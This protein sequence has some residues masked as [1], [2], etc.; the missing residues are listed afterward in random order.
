MNENIEILYNLLTKG[1]HQVSKPY[2]LEY[3]N[4]QLRMLDCV[5]KE[6]Y[7]QSCLIL[8]KQEEEKHLTEA[9]KK[10][11]KKECNTL[12]K[13]M[14]DE[15]VKECSLNLIDNGWIETMDNKYFLSKKFLLQYKDFIMANSKEYFECELCKILVKSSR[16]HDFCKSKREK[17]KLVK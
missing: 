11:I 6:W 15:N 14:N 13:I 1:I 17:I 3:L 5:A 9:M 16:I 4:S 12:I 2:D 8:I 7:D 10:E